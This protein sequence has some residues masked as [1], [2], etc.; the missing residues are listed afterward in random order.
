MEN[1]NFLRRGK[2]CTILGV[3]ITS[4]LSWESQVQSMVAKATNT[5]WTLRRMKALGVDIPTLTQFWRTEGRVHLEAQ[6]PLWHSSLTVAQSRS[7]ARAQRVAMAAITGRWHPSHSEQ[8]QELALEPLDARRIRLCERFARRTATRSRHQD[9]FPL[10]AADLTVTTRRTGRWLYR[11]PRCRTASY[12]R[13][14]VPYLT[15]LLNSN[16]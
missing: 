4:S 2:K 9:M 14:A 6:A 15:R 3:K 1:L 10:V 7:L 16:Q 12:R 11:E 8:L 5:V 13:S